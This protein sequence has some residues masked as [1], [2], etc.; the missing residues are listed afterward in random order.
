M[1]KNLPTNAGDAGDTGLIP[2]SGRSPG[3][4]NG[5]PLKYSCLGNPWTEEPAGPQFIGSQ[6]VGHD[7]VTG[8]THTEA[9]SNTVPILWCL[10]FSNLD[11]LCVFGY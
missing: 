5:N 2:G 3:I 4:G 8:H 1:V 11:C 7:W 6:K 9:V 10:H